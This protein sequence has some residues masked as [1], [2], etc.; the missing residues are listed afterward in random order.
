MENIKNNMTK[1][2]N[3]CDYCSK[4]LK[5]MN[6][7]NKTRHINKH[8]KNGHEKISKIK[9][10]TGFFHKQAAV[11]NLASLLDYNNVNEPIIINEFGSSEC[12]IELNT[13][14]DKSFDELSNLLNIDN[15]V[16]RALCALMRE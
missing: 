13:N 11:T 1:M 3:T 10:I 2:V 9:P 16:S 7:E 14:L 5:D 8:I 6:V 4:D 15:L 12:Q